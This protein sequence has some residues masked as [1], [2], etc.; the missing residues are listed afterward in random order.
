M[1]LYLGC[2]MWGLNTWV[3]SFFP[4]GTKQRDF[5]ATYSRRLNTVEGNTTFYAVPDVSTVERWR[6]ETPP[7]FLFCLKVPQEISHSKR[8]R[9]IEADL[10]E[11]TD[12]LQRLQDRCGPTFLQL[13]PTFG[14]ALFPLLQDFIQAWPRQFK[15]AVEPRHEDYLG[16][17]SMAQAFQAL[18]RQHDMALCEFDTRGLRSDTTQSD[19]IVR[20]ARERKPDFEPS[21]I[22]PASFAFV[23]YC[24]H[25]QVDQNEVWLSEW[26]D[27][28]G[29]WL[30]RGD[31]VYFFT[32][33]PDDTYAPEVARRLHRLIAAR[34]ALPDLPSWG[35]APPPQPSLFG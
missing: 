22:R 14:G 6:D 16:Q 9:Q 18:L 12:R 34:V 28:I 4:S 29:Q 31:D 35:E 5:L 8:L 19:A 3:G 33:H 30:T 1:T 17:G 25:P 26:A 20:G 11:F 7:V 10:A 23:R 2:P 32:H 15:L 24:G 13:P 27:H 21:F